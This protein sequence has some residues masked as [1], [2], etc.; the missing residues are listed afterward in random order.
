MWLCLGVEGVEIVYGGYRTIA[1]N[2]YA[3]R[4][5]I[6]KI[7]R[8]NTVEVLQINLKP[9]LKPETPT[10]GSLLNKSRHWSSAWQTSSFI[11]H[12]NPH[13]LHYCPSTLLL[14]SCLQ[15][16]YTPSTAALS[17][18]CL[19]FFCQIEF[20]SAVHAS[21]AFTVLKTKV[22]PPVG[23]GYHIGPIRQ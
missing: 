14:S 3:Q 13:V 15:Y 16:R 12:Y 2:M 19:L 18:L 9:W 4:K 8:W 21:A 1:M 7:H 6:G 23:D 17:H 22:L 20:K 10:P 5:Q 11:F